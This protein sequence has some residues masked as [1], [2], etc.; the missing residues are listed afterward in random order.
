MYSEGVAI[1]EAYYIAQPAGYHY[2]HLLH[3]V[4]AQFARRALAS[5]QDSEIAWLAVRTVRRAIP[6]DIEK[7][8]VALKDRQEAHVLCCFRVVTNRI[9]EP[10]FISENQFLPDDKIKLDTSLIY[11]TSLLRLG[12]FL[13][14]IGMVE[15]AVELLVRVS[16]VYGDIIGPNDPIT[17][18]V[19]NAR[20]LVLAKGGKLMEAEKLYLEVLKTCDEVTEEQKPNDYPA[21][22]TAYSLAA[23][24][25]KLKKYNKSEKLYQRVL[26]VYLTKNGP[27]DSSTTRVAGELASVCGLQENLN[28][29]AEFYILVLHGQRISKD[30]AYVPTL[31]SIRNLVN[32]TL[33]SGKL[34][35]AE[36]LA[37][38]C[39]KETEQA[40]QGLGTIQALEMLELIREMYTK[41]GIFNDTKRMYL[42]ASKTYEL[43]LPAQ[44]K[45][46]PDLAYP[47]ANFYT[48]QRK[49][50]KAEQMVN[51][52]LRA[53]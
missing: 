28:E 20:A 21:V 12:K 53:Y 49:F 23:L 50:E 16:K 19:I 47:L 1:L 38:A 48:L 17:L 35:E 31:I 6:D 42:R 41:T 18:D 43:F 34:V 9:A 14:H 36:K 45:D 3:P 51:K 30:I 13:S 40:T 32:V 2:S 27:D 11:Y 33:A 25:K 46:M 7:I 5:T 15:E 10:Y 26:D 37:L 24:Q 44:R 4:I 39:L 52:A 29:A 8:K 22:R